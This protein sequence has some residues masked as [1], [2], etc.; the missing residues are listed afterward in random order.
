MCKTQMHIL[1]SAYRMYLNSKQNTTQ[2][3]PSKK[4]PF[5]NELHIIMSDKRTTV[6]HFLASSSGLTDEESKEPDSLHDENLAASNRD[7][8][9]EL[10]NST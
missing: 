6:P 10:S 8:A 2:A 1:T 4:L 5:F 3:A 9:E 7:M